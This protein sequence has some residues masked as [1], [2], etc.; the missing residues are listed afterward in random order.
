MADRCSGHARCKS[1]SC[2]PSPAKAGLSWLLQHGDVAFRTIEWI[3]AVRVQITD[4][5][6]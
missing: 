2:L 3:A 4:D 6:L 1:S 5:L